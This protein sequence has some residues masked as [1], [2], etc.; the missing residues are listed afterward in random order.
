MGTLYKRGNVWWV[1]YYC[2]GRCFRESSGSPKKAVAKNLLDKREGDVV[3]GRFFGVQYDK[4]TYDELAEAFL[5]DYRI[6]KKKSLS[7]AER[8]VALLDKVFKGMRVID[9]ITPKI[10]LYIEM[11]LNDG[12]K[13]ATIN[14]ELAALKRMLNLGAKQTPPIVERMPY[15]PMLKENNVR[16]GFFEHEDFLALYKAL[17]SYL[18]PVVLFGYK[19]GW[20][21]R[22]IIN[23]TWKQVDRVNGC[24]R[25]E[26]GETKNDDAR[27]IYFD[28]ELA[29]MFEELWQLQKLRKTLSAYV[30]VKPKSG[31][32]ILRFDK[33]WKAA[34]KKA[35]L[36]GYL[37]HDLRRTA[38]RNMVRAGVPEVIAMKI[39]GHKTRSVFDRYNIVSDTDLKNAAKSYQA[40]LEEQEKNRLGHNLGTICSF[41]QKTG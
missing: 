23:M 22:E 5:Q 25:L 36:S 17:P 39:S 34:C 14:R 41:K 31:N 4:T 8:S 15:F 29:K 21:S 26:T 11:R 28:D 9:I 10:R 3:Q 27:V 37:F 1:K 19:S 33:A 13:N 2:N 40:Y 32:R 6:N 38:V 18:K 24:A 30:F 35:K 20:R 7:R 12:V 16:K